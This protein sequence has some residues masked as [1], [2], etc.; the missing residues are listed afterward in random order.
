MIRFHGR[1]VSVRDQLYEDAVNWGQLL[2]LV[3]VVG[4][5]LPGG[6][7]ITE[8]GGY[9]WGEQMPECDYIVG[10]IVAKHN[11]SQEVWADDGGTWAIEV[12]VED[13]WAGSESWLG[14]WVS[15]S[16]YDS[17]SVGDQASELICEVSE[18]ES[19]L[20]MFEDMINN[21]WL[22]TR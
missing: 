18:H 9:V 17:Y 16:V 19:I 20:A 21:G 7:G 15:E 11:Y 1:C 6:E 14:I 10:T 3:L 5:I 4:A 8:I 13:S 12:S 22:Y 2:L